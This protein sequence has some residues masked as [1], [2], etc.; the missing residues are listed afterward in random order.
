MR[1]KRTFFVYQGQT[2]CYD[3]RHWAD[4]KKTPSD[5]VRGKMQI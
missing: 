2:D 1:G 3:E 4:E 5:F